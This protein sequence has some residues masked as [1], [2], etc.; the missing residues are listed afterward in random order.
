MGESTKVCM[1][2]GLQPVV[3]LGDLQQLE[4]HRRAAAVAGKQGGRGRQPTP[5]AG[6]GQR[7]PLRVDAQRVRLGVQVRQ[8]GVAVVQAGR[9][10]VLGRQAVVDRH[11]DGAGVDG[12]H[13]RAGVLGLDAADHEAATVDHH[14]AGP[15]A[16]AAAAPF[17]R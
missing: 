4:A 5:G 13:G 6:P 10:G 7:H 8:R 17:G 3:E 9:V 12:H 14:D 15:P 1:D 2:A 11:H 16:S